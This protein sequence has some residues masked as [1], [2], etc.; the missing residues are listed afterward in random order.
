MD[1]KQLKYFFHVAQ[2]G[3]YTRAADLLGVAQP[4]LSRQIRLLETEL[5][6][7]LLNRHGRGVSLTES[8]QILLEHCRVILQQLDAAKEDLHA[9][10]GKL[11]GHVVLG[12]PPTIGKLLS[13]KLIKAFRQNMPEARLRITEGLTSTLQDNL[14]HGKIDMALLHNPT[15]F[16]EIDTHLLHEE[17]LCLMA[18]KNDER[19]A[20]QNRVDAA[21]LASLPLILPSVPNTFRLLI[22]QEM[23]R[24]NLKANVILEMDSVETML[25]LVGEGMGYSI[26]STYATELNR[27]DN[28]KI[29]PIE[30]PRFTSRLY[31]AT[32]NK[33]VLTRTQRELSKLLRQLCEEVI[34]KN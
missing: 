10:S 5:R 2:Q 20:K 4:V 29:I 19:F 12:L 18:A 30:F 22:E 21:T 8:G 6:H 13:V 26:L 28:V 16:A 34:Q 23:A 31:L 1:L 25:Q 7:N 11:G 15:H 32:A 27:H 3:S 17:E 24:H 33:H 9:H 14:L